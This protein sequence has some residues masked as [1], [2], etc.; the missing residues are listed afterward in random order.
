MGIISAC[1]LEN[2]T[3]FLVNCNSRAGIIYVTKRMKCRECRGYLV[4]V[5]PSSSAIV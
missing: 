1:I 4:D 5:D 3:N 2:N